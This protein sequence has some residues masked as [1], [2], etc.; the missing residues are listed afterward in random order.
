MLPSR[1]WSRFVLCLAVGFLSLVT[2]CGGSGG[3]V[4]VE[5]ENSGDPA[6]TSCFLEEIE[7]EYG[8]MVEVETC[9]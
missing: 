7:D 6:P 2:A 1:L 5:P 3:D 4:S 8:M 9:E